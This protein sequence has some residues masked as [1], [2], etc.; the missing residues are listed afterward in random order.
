[1]VRLE[2]VLAHCLV[3]QFLVVSTGATV[4]W[5]SVLT[6]R[7]HRS[8]VHPGVHLLTS[9]QD[10]LYACTRDEL[11][12]IP[13]DTHVPRRIQLP[14]EDVMTCAQAFPSGILLGSLSGEVLFYNSTVGIIGVTRALRERGD[15]VTGLVWLWYPEERLVV[16]GLTDL[17]IF[18]P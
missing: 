9:Y 1:M 6:G 2:M 5:I 18:S 8:I 13:S 7:V 15:S 11:L 12:I 16:H 17:Y 3:G 14:G 4:V 10:V